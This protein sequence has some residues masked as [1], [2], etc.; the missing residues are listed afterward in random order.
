M[1]GL[2]N[3]Q[4]RPVAAAVEEEAA[5]PAPEPAAPQS[6]MGNQSKQAT[7]TEQKEL[8]KAVDRLMVLLYEKEKTRDSI[9]KM[10]AATPKDPR[11]AVYKTTLMV[12]RQVDREMDLSEAVLVEL[13]P[14]VIDMLVELAAESGT[15][16]MNDDELQ[17][18]LAYVTMGVVD[19]YGIDEEGG[20]AYVK[21]MSEQEKA[22][23]T[24]IMGAMA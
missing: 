4:K 13:I 16:E 7:P 10:L 9:L 15:F 6:L 22:E 5:M 18:V 2:L 11:E 20:Q 24:N 17:Q 14:T 21:N 19:E 23:L 1:D 12:I 8:E 3:A